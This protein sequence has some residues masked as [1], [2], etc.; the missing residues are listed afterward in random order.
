M[1]WA[2]GPRNVVRPRAEPASRPTG[3]RS[4]ER[5]RND[6]PCRFAGTEELEVEGAVEAAL[7]DPADDLFQG[8][9]AISRDCPARQRAVTE[10]IVADLDQVGAR[11]SALDRLAK[12]GLGPRG[13]YVDAHADAGPFGQRNRVTQ[14]VDQVQVSVQRRCRLDQQLDAELTRLGS[15]RGDGGA[16]S[17]GGFLPGESAASARG[18]V[19]RLG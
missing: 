7:Q 16:E 5:L 6:P 19:D 12:L 3:R 11:G 2:L 15:A 10:Y 9:C 17:L 8:N 13:K 18:H 14:G 4:C 1:R